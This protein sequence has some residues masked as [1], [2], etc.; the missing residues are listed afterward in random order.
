MTM[1][2]S[3]IRSGTSILLKPAGSQVESED[4]RSFLQSLKAENLRYIQVIFDFSGVRQISDAALR[5]LSL[6]HSLAS[7]YDAR[8]KVV[9]SESIRS[10]IAALGLEKHLPVRAS[11][12]ECEV[13]SSS[14]DT[15]HEDLV[16]AIQDAVNLTLQ[17]IAG[18]KTVVHSPLPS[19]AGAESGTIELGAI[20]GL[21]SAYFNGSILLVLPKET[22]LGIMSRMFGARYTE[23]NDDIKDGPAEI[24]NIILGNIRSSL[25][26]KGFALA[27]AI[28]S[29]VRGANVSIAT[30]LGSDN[31][32]A[33][34]FESDCGAFHIKLSTAFGASRAAA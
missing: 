24:L 17:T 16:T 21:S 20:A 8:V 28:P 22:F 25:N 14:T 26:E 12:Q 9:G 13:E 2:T 29:T 7:Q 15:K 18:A 10:R 27:L 30:P 33:L 4:I 1:F 11:I 32:V 34:P 3:I 5:S 23:I 6:V 19:H 31:T